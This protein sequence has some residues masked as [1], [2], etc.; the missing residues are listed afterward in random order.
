M[1]E[2]TTYQSSERDIYNVNNLNMYVSAI[3]QQVSNGLFPNNST[4]NIQYQCKTLNTNIPPQSFTKAYRIHTVQ[5]FINIFTT[6]PICH[7]HGGVGIGKTQLALL[8]AEISK[9]NIYWF[10]LREY[11]V[12]S[13]LVDNILQTIISLTDIGPSSSQN[14]WLENALQ[15]LS[16]SLF[17]FDD[18]LRFQSN[19]SVS[20]LISSICVAAQKHDIKL[21]ITSN[22]EPPFRFKEE[23]GSQYHVTQAPLFTDTEIIELF[24]EHGASNT[25]LSQF[26]NLI[27]ATTN[28]HPMLLMAM[29]SYLRQCNWQINYNNAPDLLTKQYATDVNLE[30]Q[31]LVSKTILG[32]DKEMLYR[33][34]LFGNSFD[35][36]GILEL[37]NV[38]PA[39]SYPQESINN[40]IGLWLQ[41]DSANTY[42]VSP[43]INDLGKKNLAPNIFKKIHNVIARSILKKESLS[44]FDGLYAIIHFSSA[45]NYPDA[46]FTLLSMLNSFISS[47]SIKKDDWGITSIWYDTSLPIG[48]QHEVKILLRLA[49]IEACKKIGKD[50]NYLL[51]DLNQLSKSLK[52]INGFIGS[53]AIIATLKLSRID[54]DSAIYFFQ[55]AIQ[56]KDI[57]IQTNLPAEHTWESLIWILASQMNSPSK[58]QTW[59]QTFNM[60]SEEQVHSSEKGIIFKYAFTFVADNIW[61][62]EHKKPI[63][64]Q[65]WD[66][67]LAALSELEKT[68]IS[69]NSPLI[70]AS[71]IRAQAIVLAEYKKDVKN[72]VRIAQD[73]IELA[74]D[75]NNSVKFLLSEVIGREYT[76]AKQYDKALPWFKTIFDMDIQDFISDRIDSFILAS[77]AIGEFDANEAVK[78]TARS[79]T[80]AFENQECIAGNR[81]VQALAEHTIAIWLASGIKES[82]KTY[83]LAIDHLF[84]CKDDSDTWKSLF[85]LLGHISGYFSAI[86]QQ[87]IPPEFT[88]NGEIYTPPK[89][90]M[91]RCFNSE[92]A[93]IYDAAKDCG[94][95]THVSMFA[96]SINAF[97]SAERWAIKAYDM[98]YGKSANTFM[99]I[100]SIPVLIKTERL[101][102]AFHLSQDI[103]AFA[104]AAM[105]SQNT[106]GK[107]NNVQEILGNRPNEN[108][109]QVESQIAFRVVLPIFIKIIT[110]RLSGS[111]NL[112]YKLSE[113]IDELNLI[114]AIASNPIFWDLTI[115]IVISFK[116]D[117]QLN[118]LFTTFEGDYSYK[119]V[120]HAMSYLVF[121]LKETPQKMIQYLLAVL[122]TIYEQLTGSDRLLIPLFADFMRLLAKKVFSEKRF[123]F[124]MPNLIEEELMNVLLLPDQIV[125]SKILSTL[126][127]GLNVSIPEIAKEF[128]KK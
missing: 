1:S 54:F 63:N 105:L 4:I 26:M 65:N 127:F 85:V 110:L 25:F 119:T 66:Q 19:S 117:T 50:Y 55:I 118:D 77:E 81:L 84:L 126:A 51:R 10:R 76:I 53:L 11:K 41:R 6:T 112:E 90:G 128:I 13:Q 108:W 115:Q 36:Q 101:I 116:T 34:S 74:S 91:F 87:G 95:C 73:A 92:A 12:A 57:D 40:L 75:S 48:M 86:A 23:L 56:C 80:L 125:T 64:E 114:K 113:F 107:L 88:A 103:F 60:F 71:A 121:S 120:L 21:I 46:A 49:Q 100:K 5:S 20:E 94:L 30:I 17:V 96:E 16:G 2:Q 7:I 52:P 104:C 31:N 62:A 124:S 70:W 14:T 29:I 22:F 79:V 72:A 97:E 15:K 37:S 83:E 68:A 3:G 109:N 61:L 82:Y 24:M 78:Y 45:E 44:S 39:I 42:L 18:L 98:G 122:P 28:R 67:V 93:K 106:T 43:L 69:K 59:L 99:L 89:R 38:D 58:L 8:I 111:D 102:E 32:K 27:I 35:D 47:E 33:L 123:F 9:R